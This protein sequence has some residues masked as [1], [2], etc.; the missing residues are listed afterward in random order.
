MPNEAHLQGLLEKALAGQASDEELRTLVEALKQD[1]NLEM[2][3]AVTAWLAGRSAAGYDLPN[4]ARANSMAAA[5][6]NADKLPAEQ[7]L[8]IQPK[9]PVLA[10]WKKVAAAAAILAVAITAYYYWPSGKPAASGITA[11]N[12]NQPED[13]N[14]GNNKARLILAD[15]SFV[16]LDTLAN[17]TLQVQ[18]QTRIAKP[19]DGQ[20][21]YQ[22]APA[23][24]NQY[25]ASS[26]Y[27]T[28]VVPRGGQ[29]QLIL[30]D[31]TQVWLNAA[32][33]LR[34]P[35]AFTGEERIVELEGEGYFEVAKDAARPFIVRTST[36]SVRVLGTH[37]NVCAYPQEDWKATLLE[38]KVEVTNVKT[39]SAAA[40][41]SARPTPAST[42]ILAPG[43]QAIITA[44]ASLSSPSNKSSAIQ[45]QAADTD[46]AIAWKEGYFHFSD[47]GVKTIMQ[48]I[49]RWYDVDIVYQDSSARKA[50]FNGRIDRTIKLS[51]VVNALKQGGINCTI[52]QRRLLVYP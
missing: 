10:L 12:T 24:N 23:D 20:L 38:G 4:E 11:A 13:I 15:G 34:F 9:T 8:P 49:S 19:R 16:L 32:S 26:F 33:Y 42:R 47:A 28:V 6:L 7:P 43:Q 31:G 46:E 35:V 2:T 44:Q 37:F 22:T 18:G 40:K 27:N 21:A 3:E 17:G 25:A 51:G 1:D 52:E 5:I 14:P 30:A 48:Q 50:Q 29:Y 39:A 41:E 45:V 36:A